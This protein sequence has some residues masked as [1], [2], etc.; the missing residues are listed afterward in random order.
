MSQHE[1]VIITGLSGAGKSVAMKCFE[2]LGYFCVDNLPPMLM[3]KFAQ[4][5]ATSS[6]N[7]LAMVIDVRGREF[8]PELKEAFAELPALGFEPKILFLEASEAVLVRR[9][10]ETRRRHPLA[11]N[12][13]VLQ[14]IRQEKQELRELREMADRIIDTST[15]SPHQLMRKLQSLSDL[16]G[17]EHIALHI[18]SFGFKH[19]VPAD[20][21]MVFDVRFLPNPYYV[22]EL[23]PQTGLD[24]PV[25]RYVMERP[26]T[27]EFISRLRALLDFVLPRYFDEGKQQLTLGVGCT[28]GQHRSTAISER[29]A[30]DLRA[31]G[32][33]VS[34]QH[35]DIKK[36]KQTRE[37]ASVQ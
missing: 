20:A 8:F 24:E 5:C 36:K 19:G 7:R 26:A 27:E 28:G 23:R 22:P 25:R 29:L 1:F 31:A 3:A 34:V 14:G 10:A 4:L 18:V 16:S 6:A 33:A 21:D 32:H 9:Y 2:D 12:R 37:A 15:L 17:Q 13:G 30:R 35:R 11:H